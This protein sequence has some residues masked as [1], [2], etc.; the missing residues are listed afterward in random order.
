MEA[1][2]IPAIE[3][4]GLNKHYGELAAV[5]DLDFTVPTGGCTA[6]LGPNGAGKTTAIKTLY[7]KARADTRPPA[8]I[9][10]FG[11]DMPR[12]ELEVKSLTGV[13]P[14][15][16]ALDE[17]LDVQ[18]NLS[19]FAR[20]Y[21]MPKARA[22]ERIGELLSFLEL[23]EKRRS[24]V[25][26]LSGGMKRRLIIARALLNSPRL[27]ILD[28]PTT[29]LDPQVRQLIWD[30][31]RTLRRGG[32]TVLMT[33]HY[34][35]EAFQLADDI[36]IMDKGKKVLEGAPHGLMA[37]HIE[38]HVLEVHDPSA[39]IGNDSARR[40][41]ADGEAAGRVR[42]ESSSSRTLLYASDRDELESL[43]RMLGPGSSLLRQT[44][45][46]DLFL[47]TTGRALNE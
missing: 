5:V 47:K 11:L 21:H 13:V 37:D 1:H 39:L 33:T 34:M 16:D 2:G 41:V 29:G 18:Q 24:R 46:E 44:N 27:L 15:E 25:K 28:E 35:E 45:L 43:S 19:I 40:R 10:V 22:R 26:E 32:V 14:Q 20:F 6:F 30:R 7:G 9:R 31:I 12:Q 42:S 3:V 36:I 4:Q 17:E 23:T 8:C 38:S